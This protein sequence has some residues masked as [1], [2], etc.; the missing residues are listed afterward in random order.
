MSK[1]RHR[2]QVLPKEPVTLTIDRMSHEGRGVASNEGKVAFV[3]GALPGEQVIATYTSRRG[4]FDEL[5]TL[6]VLQTSAERVIPPCDFAQICG[7]CILQHQLPAAQ[8][9]LKHQVLLDQLR[10]T[11]GLT[12]FVQL[13]PM[14][15]ATEGYRR[16]ARLAVRY[17]HKKADVLI[18]FREKNSTFITDMESCAVLVR[19]VGQLIRP[20]RSLV[21]S[22]DARREIPQIEVSVGETE[23]VPD[24][25]LDDV[26]QVTLTL[27][28]MVPLSDADLEKL[29]EFAVR[30]DIEWYLQPGGPQTIKKFWPDDGHDELRYFL[31]EPSGDIEM[32]F[33]PGDF[34][35]VNAQIN[36]QMIQQAMDLLDLQSGD[37]VL[38]L[39]CGLGN[40]TLPVARRCAHVT[41]VEGSAEMLVRARENAQRNA[42]ENISYHVADLFSDFD[43]DSWAGRQYNKI[44]LDPPRSGAIEIAARI[45]ELNPEVIVYVSC[46]PSTLARD[47]A[48]LVRQ[49]YQMTHA[50]VMDMF[51]HTGHVE[52]MAR[53]ERAIKT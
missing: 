17:V 32:W 13:P 10:H 30:Y 23:C 25:T 46:N 4:Q 18:G 24:A 21:L 34:T 41:G 38:D 39:F 22:M 33:R 1:S 35:Q 49:G 26:L 15:A 45:R 9:R 51:P 52:S 8:L 12:D 6:D 36:R 11:A 14:S 50:G 31:P 42:I 37:N 27:R 3:E 2:R 19:P 7:G 29:Q 47:A 28:H 40:F 43:T 48:E 53:F 20:L 16:K 44:L 5:R